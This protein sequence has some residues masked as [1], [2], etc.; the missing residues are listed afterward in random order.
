MAFKT[1][2]QYSGIFLIGF[3]LTIGGALLFN[4]DTTQDSPEVIKP[5]GTQHNKNSSDTHKSQVAP[6]Q[7]RD[8]DGKNSVNSIVDADTLSEEVIESEATRNDKPIDPAHVASDTAISEDAAK[9]ETSGMKFTREQAIEHLMLV[10]G[11]SRDQIE[12][13]H[14]YLGDGSVDPTHL[15]IS[16]PSGGKKITITSKAEA[17]AIISHLESK[18]DASSNPMI[19]Y[20]K[21]IEFD[22]DVRFEVHMSD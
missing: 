3:T 4:Y 19:D 12:S 18:A 20:L 6:T 10:T 17:Q 15:G 22:G 14:L 8:N 16:T 11:M 2:L 1:C 9:T 5:L 21:N 7:T 13:G